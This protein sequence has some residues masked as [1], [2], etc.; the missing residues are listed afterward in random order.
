MDNKVK[1]SDIVRE[2]S[3]PAGQGEKIDGFFIFSVIAQRA[4]QVAYTLGCTTDH[5]YHLI[6]EG[7]FMNVRDIKTNMAKR[8]CWRIPRDDVLAFLDSRGVGC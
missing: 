4:D 1:F 7:E 8:S 6:E 5:I 3:R 2:Q